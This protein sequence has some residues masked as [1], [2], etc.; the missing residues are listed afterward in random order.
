MNETRVGVIVDL[1]VVQDDIMLPLWMRLVASN[2]QIDIPPMPYSLEMSYDEVPG[3]IEKLGEI[4]IEHSIRP[5]E[6]IM[7]DI[8]PSI[9]I[10]KGYDLKERYVTGAITRESVKEFGDTTDH[11]DNLA[12]RVGGGMAFHTDWEHRY[13]AENTRESVCECPLKLVGV[14][15]GSDNWWANHRGIEPLSFLRFMQDFEENNALMQSTSFRDFKIGAKT[16]AFMKDME[17]RLRRD[18]QIVGR[19]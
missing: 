11:S 15:G 7:P 9:L 19:V 12:Y 2:D 6:L 13:K 16:K 14:D 10:E 1:E 3:V 4:G 8:S 5:M 17:K 18:L